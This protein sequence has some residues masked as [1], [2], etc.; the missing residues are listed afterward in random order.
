MFHGLDSDSRLT[1]EM[2]PVLCI[3]QASCVS[4]GCQPSQVVPSCFAYGDNHLCSHSRFSWHLLSEQFQ[5]FN[6]L[7]T[8]PNSSI[9]SSCQTLTDI[10][11]VLNP[12]VQSSPRQQI[13]HP[14]GAPGSTSGCCNTPR[15]FFQHQ[16]L[17]HFRLFL[18]L[19]ASNSQAWN[20][21]VSL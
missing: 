17:K 2:I 1:R 13:L 3:P 11:D 20:L 8:S 5:L 6:V 10:A 7:R 19:T 4:L 21:F 18:I 14:G 16:R 12:D 15:A 9:T